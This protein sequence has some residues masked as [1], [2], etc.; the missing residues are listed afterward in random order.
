MGMA[1]SI[2]AE[3]LNVYSV[4]VGKPEKRNHPEDL[5]VDGNSG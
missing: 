5:N 4:L 3:K 2:H 1:C